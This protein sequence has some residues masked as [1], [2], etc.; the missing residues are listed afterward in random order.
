MNFWGAD[1]HGYIPRLKAAMQALGKQQDDLEVDIIQMVRLVENGVEVKMS[2]RTGNAVTIRELCDEVGVDAARYYFVQRA[3]DTHLDFDMGLAKKQS[4]DNPVYY[5]QYAHARI[6]SILRQ[7]EGYSLPDS[8]D[9]LT[10]EK[11]IVLLKF[12]NEFSDVVADAAENRAPHKI[13]NYIQ[14]LAQHFHSFYNA[15]KVINPDDAELTAQ[16]LGLLTAMKI[17]LKN[18]LQL[19]G[20]EAIEKM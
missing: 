9:R 14:K 19:I 7:A 2:K 10:H 4:N 20:V 5:A 15:C 17:T 16:R 18:A 3:L 12:I 1:H 6:C 8:Y 11:E 13:C